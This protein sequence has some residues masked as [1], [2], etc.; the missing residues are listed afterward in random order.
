MQLGEPDRIQSPCLGRVDQLKALVKCLRHG[1]PLPASE[2][3]KEAEIQPRCL[4]RR[5][6]QLLF[7]GHEKPPLK[8][9]RAVC[10]RWSI[11]P[12]RALERSKGHARKM[13]IAYGAVGLI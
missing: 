10:S 11:H 12:L 8:C 5:V 1:V 4:Q 2:L 3:V 13:R 7:R 6:L 9:L